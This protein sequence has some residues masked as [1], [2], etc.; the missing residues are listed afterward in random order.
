MGEGGEKIVWHFEI[1]LSEVTRNNTPTLAE[2]FKLIFHECAI[3][4]KLRKS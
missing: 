1:E 3:K 4:L 2:A